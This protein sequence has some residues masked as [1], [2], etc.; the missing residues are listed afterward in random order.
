[1][2][3]KKSL[4][5]SI[6]YQCCP[7]CREESLFPPDTLYSGRFMQMNKSCPCCGQSFEPEPGFYLGVMYTSYA[8]HTVLFFLITVALY[9]IWGS[10]NF[11][12]LGF[13][14]LVAVIALLP[15]TFRLSR[16]IWIHI[17]VRYEGPCN[18][19]PKR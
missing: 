10:P 8:L 11:F 2:P 17:F 1:M 5:Y 18:E 9:Q 3:A 15:I 13:L 12:F 6:F 4:A 14:F 16:S 7:R 19:I